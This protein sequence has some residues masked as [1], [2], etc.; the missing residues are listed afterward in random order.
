MKGT[1]KIISP[2]GAMVGVRTEDGDY[3]VLEL[4]G[5][6]SP[7]IGDV[8]SGQLDN[9]GGEE[10]RNLTQGEVWDVFIQDIYG[11]RETAINLMAQH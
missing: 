11:S 7:E 6:F 2:C 3:S 4:L 9:L 1:I 5:G 10:V 8:I